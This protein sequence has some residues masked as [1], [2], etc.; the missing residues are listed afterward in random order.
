MI[1]IT[2][3]LRQA[4]EQAGGQPVRLEDPQT[5]SRYVLLQAEVYERLQRLCDEENRLAA[6]NH[7]PGISEVFEDWNDPVWMP[8][9]N[10]THENEGCTWS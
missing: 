7:F 10:W 1:T 3:E 9:T 6:E 4:I 2:P 5:S 8:I